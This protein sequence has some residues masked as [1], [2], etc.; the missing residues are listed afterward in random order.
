M[1]LRLFAPN[2][3]VVG[4]PGNIL[5]YSDN[6]GTV[7]LTYGAGLTGPATVEIAGTRVWRNGLKHGQYLAREG[8]STAARVNCAWFFE[9]DASALIHTTGTLASTAD[10]AYSQALVINFNSA[11]NRR[12]NYM[13]GHLGGNASE[14]CYSGWYFSASPNSGSVESGSAISLVAKSATGA[15]R[16]IVTHDGSTVDFYYTT[17]TSRD[18]YVTRTLTG[19]MGGNE[20][21]AV[22]TGCK[23]AK[24]D[25]LPSQAQR[26]AFMSAGTLPAGLA[27]SYQGGHEIDPAAPVFWDSAGVLDLTKTDVPGWPPAAASGDYTDTSAVTPYALIAVTAVATTGTTIDATRPRQGVP[28]RASYLEKTE[29]ADQITV[30]VNEAPSSEQDVAMLHIYADR[31]GLAT[32]T[33]DVPG[34]LDF[35]ATLYV[36][37]GTNV[38][39]GDIVG[40]GTVNVTVELNGSTSVTPF[41]ITGIP[42]NLVLGPDVDGGAESFPQTVYMNAY[43]SYDGTLL[44]ES[45]NEHIVVPASVEIVD[46]VAEIEIVVSEEASGTVTGTMGLLEATAD[47]NVYYNPRMLAIG[48][49]QTIAWT[50][51]DDEPVKYILVMVAGDLDGTVF[52]SSSDPNLV[53]PASVEVSDHIFVTFETEGSCDAIVTATYGVRV[54]TCH[55]IVQDA[56]TGASAPS[57][58]SDD[59]VWSLPDNREVDST[60]F[61]GG[62]EKDFSKQ[63]AEELMEK[64]VNQVV[65]YYPVDVQATNYHPIYGESISKKFHPP[66]RVYALVEWKGY[67]TKNASFSLDKVPVIEVHFAKRRLEEDQGLVVKEGDFIKYGRDFYEITALNENAELFGAFNN[68]VDVSATCVKARKGTFHVEDQTFS[69]DTDFQWDA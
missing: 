47:V 25:S 13:I 6:P 26:E 43:A 19:T 49:D 22:F 45:D 36:N 67:D 41:T 64:V 29:V 37:E 69:K 66:I 56:G 17:G 28:S 30:T 60:M 35:P 57:C 10:A 53:V 15:R 2:P 42:S 61:V 52:L 68:K 38:V 11:T 39:S 20:W 50:S 12:I 16:L 54:A 44:L 4:E 34:I 32:I 48:P 51:S 18:T 55:I 8:A 40:A 14:T 65:F 5:V 58:G 23:F 33:C 59:L 24:L 1:T 7:S 21:L 9:V 46:G 62:A 3:L 63:I 31:D 27:A